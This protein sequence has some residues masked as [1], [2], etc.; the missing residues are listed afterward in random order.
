MGENIVLKEKLVDD[1]IRYQELSRPESPEALNYEWA[2]DEVMDMSITDINM[3]W[4]F[5]LEV[6][7][8]SKDEWV[9]ANVGAG[10][11]ED[12]MSTD[13]A[14]TLELIRCALPNK[15]LSFCLKNVWQNMMPEKALRELRS[16]I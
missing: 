12:M 14:L 4:K 13:S 15:E 10:P 1:W 6:I 7:S 16:L 5:V 8:K 9:L 11:L 3:C 2:A